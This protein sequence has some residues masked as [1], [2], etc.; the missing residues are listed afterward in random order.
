MRLMYLAITFVAVAAVVFTF[1][2]A[3]ERMIG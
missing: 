2:V 3:L 1:L